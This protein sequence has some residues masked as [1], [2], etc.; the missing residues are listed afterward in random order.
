MN[1]LQPRVDKRGDTS[2]ITGMQFPSYEWLVASSYHVFG[3]HEALP[4][5]INWL[6]YV[7][8]VIAFYYLVKQVSGS[9]W[10]GGVGAWCLTWSPEMYYHGVNALPDVLAL[11]ASVAGLL[12]FMKWHENKHVG[13]LGLSLAGVVLGGL[14]KLQYLVVGFPIAVWVVRDVLQRRYSPLVIVQLAVYATVSVGLSLAW[15]AYAL[16][17][18]QISGLTNFG[19]EFRPAPD[20]A[21]GFSIIKRNLLSDW[22]ELLLGYGTLGLLLVGLWRL[23]RHTPVRHP[24]FKPGLLWGL[25]LAAYYVIELSQMQGHTYYM[26]PLL[27]VLIL[28]ATWG[29]AWLQR[30]P[31]AKTGLIVLLVIQPIWAFARVNYGRWLTRDPDVAPELFNPVTRAQL[32]AATPA[33]A[34]C[35]VGPDNSGCIDFYFLHKKGFGIGWSGQ[36]VEPMP[37]GRLYIADCIARGARYLYTNDTIS[38]QDARVQ[39]YLEQKLTRVGNFVVWKL[40]THQQ[41]QVRY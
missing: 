11:T 21:T 9:V 39:P 25:A 36:L 22:P 31:R 10:L 2:G 41:T 8:G 20:L 24:W 26:L 32:E 30:F 18:I 16:H 29:A 35:L 1:I 23:I 13:Y 33:D 40:R 19:I 17:L 12:W 38:L 6:I 15:Y 5:V 28:L 37:S 3:F 7:A 27:P 4:R 34:L 14:T